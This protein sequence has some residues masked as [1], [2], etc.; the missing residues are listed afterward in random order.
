MAGVWPGLVD[1]ADAEDLYNLWLS[2]NDMRRRCLLV[3][4]KALER[5]GRREYHW[6]QNLIK[7]LEGSWT[8]VNGMLV[9]QG[10]RADSTSL[11]DYLDAVYT[12]FTE[13]LDAEGAKAFE[14][15]LRK[16]TGT[17]SKPRMSGRAELLGFAKD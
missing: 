2:E 4:R 10:V 14:A 9:R 12:L 11:P 8:Q 13:K 5:A 1:D 3:S 6:T 15:R 16:L 7:E 17:I